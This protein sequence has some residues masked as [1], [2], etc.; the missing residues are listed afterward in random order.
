VTLTAAKSSDELDYNWQSATW[1]TRD[2]LPSFVLKIGNYYMVYIA[3]FFSQIIYRE[4]YSVV[5][6]LDQK[7]D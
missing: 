3:L 4:L 5:L 6:I 2:M 1:Q 7:Q